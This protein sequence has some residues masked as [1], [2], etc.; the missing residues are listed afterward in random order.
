LA[1]KR[2]S[3]LRR[4][5]KYLVG[6]RPEGNVA[7]GRI[8]KGHDVQYAEPMTRTQARRELAKMP[9]KGGVIFELVPVEKL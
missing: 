6:Y 7:Y 5:H 2:L 8:I 4:K 1:E 3:P 9:C